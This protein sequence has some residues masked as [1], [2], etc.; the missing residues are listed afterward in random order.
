[1]FVRGAVISGFPEMRKDLEFAQAVRVRI[2][3]GR[4]GKQRY[5]VKKRS[6]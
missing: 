3:I 2:G 5:G 4:E 6:Y 1:M